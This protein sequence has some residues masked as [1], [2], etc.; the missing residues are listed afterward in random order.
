[1]VCGLSLCSLLQS[2]ETAR[3]WRRGSEER[4]AAGMTVCWASGERGVP[5]QVSA[6]TH[7]LVKTSALAE[8]WL[9][10]AETSYRKYRS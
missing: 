4:E 1:M 5:R 7:G 9:V 10:Y 6:S 3:C 2:T 8:T